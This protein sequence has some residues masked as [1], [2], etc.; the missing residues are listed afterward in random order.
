MAGQMQRGISYS[1]TEALFGQ[2]VPP[3]LDPALL[4]SELRNLRPLID[5]LARLEPVIRELEAIT[6]AQ[7]QAFG[8]AIGEHNALMA[9]LDHVGPQLQRIEELI[10]L[11]DELEVIVRRG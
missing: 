3:E 5:R 1:A 2:P 6:V 9:R 11:L 4:L 10:Q 8:R 7:I